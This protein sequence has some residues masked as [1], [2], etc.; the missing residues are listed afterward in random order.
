MHHPPRREPA[1][2]PVHPRQARSAQIHPRLPPPER[3]NRRH[4]VPSIVG[5]QLQPRPE[6]QDAVARFDA[7][8]DAEQVAQDVAAVVDVGAGPAVQG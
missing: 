4:I 3:R 5:V 7:A 8:E 1:Q 6:Q 2:H